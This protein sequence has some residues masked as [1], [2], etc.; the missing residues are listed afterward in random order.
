M[1]LRQRRDRVRDD[2]R[3]RVR[4][5]IVKLIQKSLLRHKFRTDIE[6]F[7]YT[8]SSCL[9]NVRIAILKCLTKRCRQVLGNFLHSNTSHRSNRHR[10]NQR[11]LISGISLERIHSKNCKIR[12]RLGIVHDVKIDQLLQLQ[13]SRLH[14]F[15]HVGK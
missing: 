15:Q 12:F 8:H 4:Y 9:T 5:H 14:S 3:I 7:R 10:T 11:V 6:K 13:I 2:H 1:N